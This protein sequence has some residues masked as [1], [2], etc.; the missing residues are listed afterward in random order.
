MKHFHD[1]INQ[2]IQRENDRL[3]NNRKRK[4]RPKGNKVTNRAARP[5]SNISPASTILGT[6]ATDLIRPSVV[7]PKSS[8]V[9]PPNPFPGATP[10]PPLPTATRNPQ[11]SNLGK[12]AATSAQ[13]S[14]VS[15]VPSDVTPTPNGNINCVV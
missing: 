7:P 1:T 12:K 10:N 15:H 9:R 11:P 3:S 8:L 2:L 4:R 13:S 5:S 14:A 6:S